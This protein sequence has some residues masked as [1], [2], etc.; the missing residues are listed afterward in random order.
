MIGSVTDTICAVSTPKGKGA[1]AIIRISGPSCFE[2]CE[3]IFQSKKSFADVDHASIVHGDI[4]QPVTQEIIDDVLVSKFC[5]PNSFTGEN[6][7]EINCHGGVYVVQEIMNLVLESGARLAEPGE[8]TKRAFL[9]GKMDLLQ[10]ESVADVIDAQT[11]LSLKYAQQQ[12]SGV[13]SEKLS[14]LRKN[15][16]KQLGLLEVELDFSEE[17]IEFVSR[18]E[19]A[20]N[21]NDL[22]TEI[23]TLLKSFKFGKIVREGVHLVLVGKPNVGKSSVMNRLLEEERAIVSEIPGTTRDVIEESLDIDGLL[24]KM[25]D[26]AGVR[27][28]KDTIESKGVDR[29]KKTLEQ[30]D[31]VLFI[32]D[33]GE[34]LD[35]LDYEAFEIIQKANVDNVLLLINKIDKNGNKVDI[36]FVEQFPLYCKISA[37]TGEGFDDFKKVLVTSNLDNVNMESEVVFNKV[38]HRDAL[39]RCDEFVEHARDSIVN[40][41]SPEFIAMD[42][43]AALD[44]LGEVT[45]EVTTD[46][47][48]NDIFS[49]FCIGK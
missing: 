36:S 24:F 27:L 33:A 20:Q 41:L 13:L 9:N 34:P 30:A 14:Q 17:D 19:L 46:D 15:L 2:I 21:L 42:M 45:G 4:V 23:E 10:A 11:K 39:R 8:F 37:L 48:L 1:I 12:L 26:T 16:I 22:D 28:T 31:Q 5:Q 35:Q 32:V 18:N 40:Q 7:V 38:R 6:V 43:R 47:V 3:K 29:T 44:A 25:S 49:S